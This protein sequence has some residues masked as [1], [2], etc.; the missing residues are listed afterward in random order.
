MFKKIQWAGTLLFIFNLFPLSVWGDVVDKTDYPVLL[1]GTI[2]TA[3]TAAFGEKLVSLSY[4]RG[5]VIYREGINQQTLANNDATQKVWLYTDKTNIYALWWTKELDAKKLYIRSSGDGGKTFAP[6]TVISSGGVLPQLVFA[7][8]G[9]NNVS[10][11]YVTE[12]FPG[13]QI[14]VN[15]SGDN[16]KSWQQEDT[17]LNKFYS[18]EGE[19]K[20]DPLKLIEEKPELSISSNALSPQLFYVADDLIAVWQERQINDGKVYLRLVSRMARKGNNKSYVWGEEANLHTK[21]NGLPIE[22]SAIESNGAIYIYGFMS[23]EGVLVFSS[24]NNGMQ[25]QSYPAATGTSELNSASWFNAVVSDKGK[26]LISYV[27]SPNEGKEHIRV[28]TLNLTDKIW[29]EKFTSFKASA[30]DNDQ[31][32]TRSTYIDLIKM[33]DDRLIVAW[34]D[35]RYLMP[36]IMVSYSEDTGVTWSEPQ[37]LS[38]PG[39]SVGKFP[40]LVKSSDSRELWATFTYFQP[41]SAILTGEKERQ[42][43]AKPGDGH[44]LT[45]LKLKDNA[46]AEINFPTLNDQKILSKSQ[47]T[48]RLKQRIGEFWDLRIKAKY[49]ESWLYFDPLYKEYFPRK[50]WVAN[51]GKISYLDYNLSNVEV[52]ALIG[53][54]TGFVKFTIPQMLLGEDDLVESPPPQE[55]ELYGRWGWFYDDWYY[56]PETMFD[57]RYNF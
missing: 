52:S 36:I 42:F 53:K 23:G 57:N 31:F 4:Q 10:V 2:K 49:A 15:T 14:Y 24:E 12:D 30:N 22:M 26:L 16:G 54:S 37:S 21:E 18:Q 39:K 9:G 50:S 56:M 8:D 17:Q 47:K 51:Q 55:S 44:Y 38:T 29:N 3:S 7:S 25:W 35:Y 43:G 13:Y 48:K 40:E 32:E 19:V 20:G 11:A 5:K 41:N 27:A 34:E 28:S 46:S 1:S 33:N 6:E 45:F